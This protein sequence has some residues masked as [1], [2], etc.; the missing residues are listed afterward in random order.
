[1]TDTPDDDDDRPWELPGAVRRDAERHRGPFLYRLG[2]ASVVA[3]FLVPF[4]VLPI[5][6]ANVPYCRDVVCLTMLCLTCPG[7]LLGIG[8]SVVSRAD[9]G[10]MQAGTM[11]PSGKA[12]TE[13]VKRWGLSGLLFNLLLFGLAVLWWWGG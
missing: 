5:T 6:S 2:V 11:D 9:L 3:G 12:L 1:V 8:T 4:V 10:K 7:L 13:E